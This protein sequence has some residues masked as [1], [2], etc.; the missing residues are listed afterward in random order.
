[1]CI[2]LRRIDRSVTEQFLHIVDAEPVVYEGGG[3]AAF[4]SR[5]WAWLTYPVPFAKLE[6]IAEVPPKYGF[7]AAF[8]I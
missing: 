7:R 5:C 1:M 6:T 8:E 3:E 2:T 4:R